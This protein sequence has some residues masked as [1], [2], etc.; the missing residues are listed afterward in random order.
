MLFRP[1]ATYM[2]VSSLSDVQWISWLALS[3]IASLVIL[4]MLAR[5][6]DSAAVRNKLRAEVILLRAQQQARLEAM[7]RSINGHSHEV[8]AEIDDQAEI[9]DQTTLRPAA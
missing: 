3:A 4:H 1:I 2:D 7:R 8:V 6:M 5:E 9:P